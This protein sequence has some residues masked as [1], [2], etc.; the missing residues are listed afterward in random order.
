MKKEVKNLVSII[1]NCKNG[2]KFIHRSI[3][4]ILKQTYKKFEIIF[5]DNY[6]TD[7]TKRELNKFNDKRIKYLKSKKKLKLYD[8]RN[9][10]I[11]KARGE[12]ITF[13]DVDDEWTVNK[14]YIQL[15]ELKKSKKNISFTNYWISKNLR[16]YKFKSNITK[17]NIKEQILNDYPIGILTVMIR[18][19]IFNLYKFFFNKNYEIIGDFDLF[20]RLSQKFQFQCIN[21]PLAIY[22]LHKNNLSK[23]K[24]NLEIKEIKK[25]YK[26]NKVFLTKNKNNILYKNNIREC[27][28]LFSKKKLNFFSKEFNRLKF[29][30]TKFKFFIKILSQKLNIK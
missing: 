5:F 25:W 2:E 21:K 30:I 9:K 13:L 28:Y 29:S 17:T 16:M 27:Y 26:I 20:F 11:K 18:S 14:L 24:L 4:S 22:H 3:N 7:F 1:V 10:A 15:T 23:K 12:F 8:A 19:K 6:S